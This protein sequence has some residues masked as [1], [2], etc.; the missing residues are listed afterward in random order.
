[1][2]TCGPGDLVGAVR[3]QVRAAGW[4]VCLVVNREN[5]VLGRLRAREFAADP[6]TAVDA[7]MEE[8]PG[9]IRPDTPLD[10]IARRMQERNLAGVVVTLPDGR[11][12]GV[13]LRPDA[14]KRLGGGERGQT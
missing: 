11:L 12:V 1:V 10:S 2:P 4:E 14:E 7:V 9:T 8:G 3:D 13:L 5:V 6:A